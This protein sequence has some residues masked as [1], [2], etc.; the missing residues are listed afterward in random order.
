[1]INFARSCDQLRAACAQANFAGQSSAQLRAINFSGESNASIAR[2]CWQS[3][4]II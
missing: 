4:L 3:G 2:R 1:M